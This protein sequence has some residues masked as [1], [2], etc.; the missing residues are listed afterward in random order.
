MDQRLPGKWYVVSINGERHTPLWLPAPRNEFA[1][2]QVEFAPPSA[3]LVAA[4]ALSPTVRAYLGCNWMTSSYT[5]TRSDTLQVDPWMT[6]LAYCPPDELIQREEQLSQVFAGS[7]TYT[8]T[9]SNAITT[10]VMAGPKGVVELSSRFP[11]SQTYLSII[12]A[13]R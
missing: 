8:L 10:L 12:R 4:A 13:T 3:T 5:L 11:L 7:F 2:S 6:T 1:Y 9:A